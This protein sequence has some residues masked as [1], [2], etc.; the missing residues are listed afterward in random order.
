[1]KSLFSLS[2]MSTLSRSPAGSISASILHDCM[3]TQT[4]GFLASAGQTISKSASRRCFEAH[5]SEQS[6]RSYKHEEFLELL[7]VACPFPEIYKAAHDLD[8]SPNV[9]SVAVNP[10]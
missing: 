6:H 7:I 5:Q 4:T 8:I 3:Q 1:M 10:V 9:V 2:L